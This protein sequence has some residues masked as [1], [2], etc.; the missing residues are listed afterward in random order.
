MSL[1]PTQQTGALGELAVTQ[2]F[3]A[4]GW[5]VGQDRIDIGYDLFVAPD[6]EIYKGG[7]FLVQV[8]GTTKTTKNGHIRAPVSKARLRQYAESITPVFIIRTTPEG[9][10]Y[11]LHAQEWAHQN[12]THLKGS[13]YTNVRFDKL[14]TLSNRNDFER[15]LSSILTTNTNKNTLLP[16]KDLN[17]HSRVNSNEI[18]ESTLDIPKDAKPQLSFT[19]AP[20]KE[21]YEKLKDA[22]YFGLPSKFAVEEL[23]VS[24]L[25][26]PDGLSEK[27]TQGNVTLSPL[28]AIP[29]TI[30]VIPGR[31]RNL[32]STELAVDVELFSGQKGFAVSNTRLPSLLDICIRFTESS[33]LSFIPNINISFRTNSISQTPI[34]DAD[35]LSQ[36]YLWAEQALH[37]Q[38]F[39]LELSLPFHKAPLL[40]ASGLPQGMIDFLHLSHTLGKIHLIARTTD[41]S[42]CIPDKFSISRKELESIDRAFALLRGDQLEVAGLSME[43]EPVETVTPTDRASFFGVKTMTTTLFNQAFCKIPTRF[44]LIDFRIDSIPNSSKMSI[45]P[46]EHGKSWISYADE[47]SDDLEGVWFSADSTDEDISR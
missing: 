26:M 31:K 39:Y 12:K 30:R 11:W 40:P 36:I 47:H 27:F 22:I 37:H 4:W 15:Y 23:S 20:G 25:P 34:K 18:T 41:S 7:R 14:K 44:D 35:H 2:A 28:K 9:L 19:T 10:L 32:T 17:S 16:T 3:I 1:P 29:G 8:K 46:G 5:N 21:N 43:L 42:L 45:T 33:K 24:G 6:H 38:G 13:G